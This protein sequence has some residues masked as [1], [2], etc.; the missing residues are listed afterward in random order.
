MT[1]TYQILHAGEWRK[2]SYDDIRAAID[3]SIPD[4]VLRRRL[5]KRHTLERLGEPVSTRPVGRGITYSPKATR[6]TR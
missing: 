1:Y 3:P 2:M 6:F 5:P 4:H